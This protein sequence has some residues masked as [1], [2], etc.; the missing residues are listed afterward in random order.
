M[1]CKYIYLLWYKY[2]GENPERD[3]MFLVG[4]FWVLAHD[5]VS[6]SALCGKCP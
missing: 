1:Y 2:F 6:D 4:T 5:S 3:A